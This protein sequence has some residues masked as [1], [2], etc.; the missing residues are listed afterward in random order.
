MRNPQRLKEASRREVLVLV[1]GFYCLCIIAATLVLRD[2]DLPGIY[3]DEVFQTEAA[4][5]FLS[6]NPKPHWTPGMESLWLFER[7]F[8]VTT[9]KYLGALKSK[10]LIPVFALFGATPAG[11]RP[12]GYLTEDFLSDIGENGA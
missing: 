6:A 8:P 1:C 9:L 11:G 2:L 4:V 10:A 3:Y 5:D 7:W 12:E